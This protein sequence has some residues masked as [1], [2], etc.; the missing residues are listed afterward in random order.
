MRNLHPREGLD[1]ADEVLLQQSVVQRG[2]VRVHDGVLTQL[3]GIGLRAGRQCQGKGS[4]REG[5]GG[6]TAWRVSREGGSC[7]LCP[8]AA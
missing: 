1:E 7:A 8:T 2:Q 6:Q 4:E 3:G 5:E